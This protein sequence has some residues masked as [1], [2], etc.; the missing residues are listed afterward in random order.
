VFLTVLLLAGCGGKAPPERQAVSVRVQ[1]A[2]LSSEADELRYS[3]AIRPDVQVDLAFKVS[4][5]IDQILQVRGADGR[6]RNLQDGDFVRKGTVLAR[7]R[8]NEYRDKV[9]EAQ[10]SLTQGKA[11][12]ERVARMYETST[13]SKAD[14][15]AAFARAQSSQARYDQAAVSLGDCSLRAPMDG[16]V[17]RRNIEIG[18]LVSPGAA[19]FQLADTRSVKVVFGVPDVALAAIRMGDSLRVE[20]EALPGRMLRGRVTRIAPSA[21][22]NS[23]TFEVECTIP[24]PD[25][26]LKIGMIASLHVGEG[27]EHGAVTLVPLKA[28]VRSRE[29][30]KGYAVY[31]VEAAGGKQVAR[32][33]TVQ[34][35]DVRGNSIVVTGGLQGGE[36]IVV[37]GTTLVAEDQEVR[38]VP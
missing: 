14:Y 35:G 24:N 7:V 1:A 38:V 36:R 30:P 16:T 18:S 9:A 29:D 23:R 8:D 5:Y 32:Q 13:A 31:V 12:H 37:T 22:P 3:A 10:A 28:I 6:T 21:D 27:T 34:L 4:G 26:R 33:R 19:A 11:D 15:D 17:V 2:Q 20:T 25:E